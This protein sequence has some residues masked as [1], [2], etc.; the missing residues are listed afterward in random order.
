VTTGRV[1]AGPHVRAACRRHIDDLEHG[2]ARGLRFDLE[3]VNRAIGFFRDVLRLNGGEH[4]GQPFHLSPWQQFVVGSIFGWLAADGYR[5]FRTAYLEIGKGNGKSPLAGGIGLYCLV[6]DREARA[7]V[8]AAAAK[9]DQAMILFR[10]AVAMVKQ[11]QDLLQRLVLT[12]PI[13]DP[14]HI[15]YPAKGSWFNPIG[16]DGNTQSGPRPHCSLI[17]EL[18]EH[19][20]A[21]VIDMLAAGIKG[22]RQ[23][24]QIEI[25]NSGFDRQ[26]VCYQHHEYSN[27]VVNAKPGDKDF[28]DEWFAYVCALDKG[29]DPIKDESCWPKANPNLGVSIHPPYLRK[30]VREALGMPAKLSKVKRL[31]FCMWVDAEDPWIDGPLWM[32]CEEELDEAEMLSE[33]AQCDEVVGALDLSGVN[34]LTALALVGTREVTR[35]EELVRVVFGTVEFWTPKDTLGERTR[36]DRVPYELWVEQEWMTATPGRSVDYAWVAQRIVE[37]QIALPQFKRLAFDP[38]RIK[39]LERELAQVHCEIELIPHPQG[40]Y[41]PRDKKAPDPK[42]PVTTKDDPPEPN[43]WMPRSLELVEELITD[44]RLRVRRNPCLTWNVASVVAVPD[45]Q[46]NRIFDKRKSRGRIDGIVALA[47]ATGL[48]HEKPAPPAPRKFQMLIL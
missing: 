15:G 36:S 35:L 27:R 5:R 42:R 24:L 20:N 3:L 46:N 11:S 34:D 25:T 43:L 13:L 18:H 21:G 10:D 41:K 38:Y 8:Y 30:Q 19:P 9:K 4:E 39:Y 16:R 44:K 31:N 1:P 14:D 12:G 22:R 2:P 48:A 37:L 33:L 40:Y 47:M 29:D 23:P 26:S 28:D 7:E 17:D 45:K 6:S 32:A